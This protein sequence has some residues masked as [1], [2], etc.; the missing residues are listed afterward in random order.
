MK[1]D[2]NKLKNFLAAEQFNKKNQEVFD[3]IE[4]AGG[5]M[6]GQTIEYP[7]KSEQIARTFQIHIW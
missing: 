6:D 4:E 2:E 7:L 1:Y 5:K 3:A